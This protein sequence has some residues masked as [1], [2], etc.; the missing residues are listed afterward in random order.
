M[1]PGEVFPLNALGVN[2]KILIMTRMISMHGHP[3][4]INYNLGGC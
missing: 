4:K 1:L 2:N 3:E